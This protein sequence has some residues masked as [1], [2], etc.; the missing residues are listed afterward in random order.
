M[1]VVQFVAAGSFAGGPLLLFATADL[2]F[3]RVFAAGRVSEMGLM[4]EGDWHIGR[5]TG[6]RL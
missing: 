4:G 2:R 3:R 1:G 5:F 6:T